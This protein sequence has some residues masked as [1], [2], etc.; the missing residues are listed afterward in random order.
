M[1]F[2]LSLVFLLFFNLGMAQ[3]TLKPI[4]ELSQKDIESGILV[5]VRTPKEFKA[6]HLDSAININWYDADFTAQFNSINQRKVIYLYCKVGGRSLNAA[7]CLK[8]LGFEHVVN[9]TGG[10]DAVTIKNDL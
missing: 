10:Y 6:G 5:D 2:L 3:I 7:K 9:L 8:S 1:K 4:T